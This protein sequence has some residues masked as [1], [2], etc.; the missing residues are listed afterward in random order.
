MDEDGEWL[1]VTAAAQRLGISRQAMQ[2]R[3]KRGTAKGREDNRG[4]PQVWVPAVAPVAPPPPPAVA[5]ASGATST[6]PSSSAE[7]AAIAA[8]E[9]VIDQL[10]G[11]LHR[12]RVVHRRDLELLEAELSRP[13]TILERLVGRHIRQQQ[14]EAI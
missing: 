1:T 4:S 8:L 12:E 9:R 2:W 14:P 13:L 5:S 10:R 6:A 3:L 11:D 7:V